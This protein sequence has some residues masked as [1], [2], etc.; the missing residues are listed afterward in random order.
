MTFGEV[1]DAIVLTDARVACVH[2][3]RSATAITTTSS[4]VAGGGG[5]N[6]WRLRR[7]GASQQFLSLEQ[8]RRRADLTVED[9]GPLRVDGGFDGASLLA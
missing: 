8:R 5:L 1:R 6:L 7:L 3:L 4:G 2:G 9:E